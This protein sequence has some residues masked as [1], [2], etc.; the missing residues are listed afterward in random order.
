MATPIKKRLVSVR[1][2]I[3]YEGGTFRLFAFDNVKDVPMNGLNVNMDVKRIA[4]RIAWATLPELVRAAVCE[5]CEDTV[6]DAMAG[7][8]TLKDKFAAAQARAEYLMSGATEWAQRGA[9]GVSEQSLLARA[10]AIVFADAMTKR[11]QTNGGTV[12]DATADYLNAKKASIVAEG[13]ISWNTYVARA[14]RSNE[15]RATV[16]SLRAEQAANEDDGTLFDGLD[17][18]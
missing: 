9:R 15:L 6:R 11:A 2:D 10:I 3:D 1:S 12:A 7:E 8:K 4:P 18:D 16:E 13:K 5:G 14:L 17:T